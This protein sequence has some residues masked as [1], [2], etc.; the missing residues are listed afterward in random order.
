MK[1]KKYTELVKHGLINHNEML[2]WQIIL[3]LVTVVRRKRWKPLIIAFFSFT[4]DTRPSLPPAQ[5]ETQMLSIVE[6]DM[7]WFIFS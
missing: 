2:L 4:T 7:M 1:S 6:Q 3:A 5:H